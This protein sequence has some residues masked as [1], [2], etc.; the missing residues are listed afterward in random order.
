MSSRAER[1]RTAECHR[2]IAKV[3]ADSPDWDER[4]LG[5]RAEAVANSLAMADAIAPRRGQRPKFTEDFVAR[6][7]AL[8]RAAMFGAG[9]AGVRTHR[10]ADD[11]RPADWGMRTSAIKT[12]LVLD[13]GK[14]P[15]KGEVAEARVVY[16]Q[17]SR[18]AGH[19]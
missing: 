8:V 7:D 13:R 15:S 4:F 14:V 3:I 5:P 2:V 19:E 18:R 1:E 17:R 16:R 6:V 10:I 12:I 9:R 11:R